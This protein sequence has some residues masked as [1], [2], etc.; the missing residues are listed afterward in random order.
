MASYLITGVSRGLGWEFM[1][2]LSANPDNVVVGIVRDKKATDQKVAEQLS[3]RSNITILE[4]DIGNYDALKATVADTAAVTGGSLDYLVANAAYMSTWDAYEPIGDLAANHPAQLEAELVKLTKINVVSV[5]HLIQLYIPLI[6]KSQVKKVI[7][8]T[9]GHADPEPVR[10]LDQ[11]V[12]SLYAISKAGLN[13]AIAK[14]SAQYKKEGILFLSLSPGV[15]DT[16]SASNATPE[17]QQVLWG[18][19]Q[20]FQKYAPYWKGPSTP[21][22]AV[23]AVISVWEKC[24]I[25]KGDGGAFLSHHGDKNW[26]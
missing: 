23:K 7:A 1:S 9:S 18:M 11:A 12:A 10:E 26:L 19:M 5:I 25:E 16:G 6:Q 8:I 3:D 20:T 15:A 22:E 14:F 17:Q 13:M 4:A 21:E 2:Q 24:S